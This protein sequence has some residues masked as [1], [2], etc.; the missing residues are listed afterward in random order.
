MARSKR[1]LT[2]HHI[3]LYDGDYD[4]LRE[5]FPNLRPAEVVRSIVRRTIIDADKAV[6]IE[7]EADL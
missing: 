4:R 6:K 2:P 1:G 3:Y 7:A 5:L